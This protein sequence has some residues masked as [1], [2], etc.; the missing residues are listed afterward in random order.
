MEI[1]GTDSV[2]SSIEECTESGD[3]VTRSLWISSFSLLLSSSWCSNSDGDLSSK[4]ES[5]WRFLIGVLEGVANNW[6]LEGL[7]NLIGEA[8]KDWFVT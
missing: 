4:Y 2:A 7:E 6:E 8:D 1:E 3:N 5:T